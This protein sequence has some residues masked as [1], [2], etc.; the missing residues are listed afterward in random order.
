[1]SVPTRGHRAD[2]HLAVPVPVP[3]PVPVLVLVPE[4]GPPLGPLTG[5]EPAIGERSGAHGNELAAVGRP[6]GGVG[7]VGGCW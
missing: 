6:V 2:E 4:S 7:C 3:V 5:E 1:M